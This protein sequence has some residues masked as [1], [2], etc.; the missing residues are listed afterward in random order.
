MRLQLSCCL[1]SASAPAFDLEHVEGGLPLAAQ[2]PGNT[3]ATY[4]GAGTG[5]PEHFVSGNVVGAR[6]I[7]LQGC[8]ATTPPCIRSEADLV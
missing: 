2:R 7:G 6:S 5:F 1:A 8:I 4:A 3:L